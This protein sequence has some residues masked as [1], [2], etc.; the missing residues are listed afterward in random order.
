MDTISFVIWRELASQFLLTFTLLCAL[1]LC[2]CTV[3]AGWSY[4]RRLRRV[5][6]PPSSARGTAFVPNLPREA[7]PGPACRASSGRGALAAPRVGCESTPPTVP[8][9]NHRDAG[10]RGTRT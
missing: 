4:L 9:G 3:R 2:A 7:Q 5:S 6:C 10:V 8:E 1:G